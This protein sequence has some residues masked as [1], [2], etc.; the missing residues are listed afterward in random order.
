[1]L[2]ARPEIELCR[3]ELYGESGRW[4]VQLERPDT[5]L[6]AELGFAAAGAWQ[7][8]ASAGPLHTPRSA[9]VEADF[10]ELQVNYGAAADGHLTLTALAGSIASSA[11]AISVLA[12]NIEPAAWPGGSSTLVP[13]SSSVW[14]KRQ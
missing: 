13:E 3:R 14:S 9:T 12:R 2:D 11:A 6:R 4:F 7:L 10:I 8:L 5:L 1:M